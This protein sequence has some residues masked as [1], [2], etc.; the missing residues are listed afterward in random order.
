[1]ESKGLN[2]KAGVDR[3]RQ[4]RNSQGTP[5]PDQYQRRILRYGSRGGNGIRLKAAVPG[6]ERWEVDAIRDR[7]QAIAEI[8]KQ[9]ITGSAVRSVKGNPITGR[10]LI[11]FD[12]EA[13]SDEIGTRLR[14][15]V[16]AL[17]QTRPDLFAGNGLASSNGADSGPD[18]AL[19][20]SGNDPAIVGGA[21]PLKVVSAA[22][23]GALLVSPLWFGASVVATGALAVT[24]IVTAS[25][26]RKGLQQQRETVGLATRTG[27]AARAH[28]LAR[29]LGYA[30]PYRRQIQ[31][32]SICS[33]VK[34]LFDL[35]PPFIIGAAI[36]IVASKGSTTLAALGL[37]T[38]QSQL[39][40]LAGATVVVFSFESL[41]Q[42]LNSRMWRTISQ[43]VQRDLRLDAYARV[44]N[45]AL[46]KL[47]EQSLGEV[48]VP[49]TDNINQIELFIDSG[50][51]SILQLATNAVMMITIYIFVAPGIAWI[52]ALPV[53]LL[54]W[55]TFHYERVA[56]PLYAEVEQQASM[57]NKQIINNV[58]G[59][60]TIRSFSAEDHEI[61]RIHDLS[62]AYVDANRPAIK[63]YAAFI[64]SF[65]FPV[66]A[67]FSGVLIVGGLSAA[68]GTMTIGSFTLVL[69]LVQRFLFPF[70]E[71]GGLVDSYQKAMAAIERVFTLFEMPV[72][73]QSGTQ[74]LPLESVRGEIVFDRVS[75]SYDEEIEILRDFSLRVPAGETAAVI[76]MT[77]VGKSSIIKVLLRFYEFGSGQIT[78]DGH[79]IRSLRL[80]DLRGAISLVSQD[81]FLFEGTVY[82]NIAYGTF[83]CTEQDV[84][85]AARIAAADGFIQALPNSYRTLI[86]E[87]GANLS[88]G[89]RQRICLA[90][91][92]VKLKQAPVFILDE[93]TSSVDSE[94]E[95]VIQ[96]ALTLLSHGRTTVIVAHRLSTVRD[97]HQIYVLGS[98][99]RILEQGKHADLLAMD[100][101][102][103][104][105]WRVQSDKAAM[106][107]STELPS[108]ARPE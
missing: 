59:L 107:L 80:G 53:P 95:A 42:Y 23:M 108:T 2:S 82:D 77:G 99:G 11:L 102:Y 32:A 97:A 103:A 38:V 6:R 90:R 78:L 48:A 83:D 69:Y 89:Q 88:T 39:L 25:I 71:L 62:Q 21:K 49:L 100:G 98:G 9:L 17:F 50:A 93:A 56:R 61:A 64:P 31:L 22:A 91:A 79:D 67:A 29:F 30:S 10:I 18:V 94:T 66:L 24:G 74:V 45:I 8:E 87:R 46:A 3:R 40:L 54:I 43:E 105:L 65:R 7:P 15:E 28:P 92:V 44:Q 14:S 37:V 96:K 104:R 106:E 76:G 60:S 33:V 75:F 84:H 19:S 57:L 81:L 5:R 4:V 36:N 101:Y 85:E 27:G 68:A 34:K 26:L 58:M 70:K 12:P 55:R 16:E 13:D 35:A 41:F 63:E 1:M 86:G 73:P 51:D 20:T 52:A 72:G 47:D